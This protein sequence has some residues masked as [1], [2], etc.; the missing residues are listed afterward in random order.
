MKSCNGVTEFRNF[1]EFD[2]HMSVVFVLDHRLAGAGW[3]LSI[4]DPHPDPA[5]VHASLCQVQSEEC[6]SGG[7]ESEVDEGDHRR[8]QSDQDVRVGG[9][10]CHCHPQIQRRRSVIH[11]LSLV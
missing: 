4:L 5:V 1:F 8:N 11:S 10:I 6:S 9:V 7:R 2:H 3:M